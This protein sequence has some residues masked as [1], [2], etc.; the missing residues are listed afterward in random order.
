MEED[1]VDNPAVDVTAQEP[2]PKPEAE[3]LEADESNLDDQDNQDNAEESE[4][5]DV[6][7]VEYDGNKYKVPKAIAP[8]LAKAEGLQ[9]DYTRKTMAAAETQR[10]ADARLQEV[11]EEANLNHEII[12]HIA[13]LRS[14]ESRLSQYQKVNWVQW[15]AQDSAAANAAMAEM[16]QLQNAKTELSGEVESRKAEIAARNQQ[17]AATM[18]SQA[19]EALSKP[20]PEYGWDGKFT[21]EKQKEISDYLAGQ[22]LSRQEIEGINHPVAVKTAWA[23]AQYK[24]I[25]SK[26]R[27]AVAPAKTVANPVTQVTTGK[28]RSTVDPD[29]LPM[30]QWVKWD[31]ERM[32]KAGANR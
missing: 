14:V 23:A 28:T 12:D 24:K 5:S 3:T 26:Q 8:I 16:I 4:E 31:N 6:E 21:A 7:E 25:L 30:D 10:M 9:A 2:A 19:V 18:I 13:Q 22:G 27:A 17:R 32:K 20:D 11:Q 15:Q 1:I 29:K